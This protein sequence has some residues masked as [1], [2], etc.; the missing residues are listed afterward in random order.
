MARGIC[1]KMQPI[2]TAPEDNI[3]KIITGTDTAI[4]K[5]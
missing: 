1:V 2:L 4:L 5:L 3:K